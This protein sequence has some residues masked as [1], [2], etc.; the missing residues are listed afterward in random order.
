MRSSKYTRN[1]AKRN[2]SSAGK[3]YRPNF[4]TVG[5]RGEDISLES[6]NY[7][8]SEMAHRGNLFLSWNAG[9]GRLLVPDCLTS[10]IPEMLTGSAAVISRGPW[11]A[12][13]KADAIEIMFEDDSD[14]PFCMHLSVEQCSQMLPESD[15]G[16]EFPFTIWTRNGKVGEVPGKYRRVATLPCLKPWVRCET[17]K[18]DS[19]TESANA[20]EFESDFAT[21]KGSKSSAGGYEKALRHVTVHTGH[22][23]LVP[24]EKVSDDVIKKLREVI[25]AAKPIEESDFPGGT[26]LAA[27]P[28][29]QGYS[30]VMSFAEDCMAATLVHETYGTCLRF[31]VAPKCSANSQG[32]WQSLCGENQQPDGPWCAV[33]IEAGLLMASLFSPQDVLWYADFE[34]CLAWTWIEIVHAQRR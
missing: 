12:G 16:S 10:A 25:G 13:Q 19:K 7:W 26:Y 32:M 21:P 3:C 6:T 4:I 17:N 31:G 27:I 33:L 22:T 28:N 20:H 30:I 29:C 5:N 14:S 9:A 23:A 34:Q 18:T 24:R 2:R 11:P 15:I 1:Q 8:D